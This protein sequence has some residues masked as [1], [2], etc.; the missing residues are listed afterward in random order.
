M[1]AVLT[2]LK[3]AVRQAG[4]RPVF[5]EDLQHG[6]KIDD[7]ILVEIK[8]SRFM[9][10]DTTGRNSNVTFE[11]GYALG[12]DRIV[13]WTCRDGDHDEQAFDIRQYKRLLWKHGN[14]VNLTDRLRDA[15]EQ[16]VGQGP[17]LPEPL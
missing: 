17:L 6:D 12:K 9:V 10:V 11:A 3:E 5:M 2:A 8:R 15:I 4:Y 13:L 14:E 7:R 16:V 1:D